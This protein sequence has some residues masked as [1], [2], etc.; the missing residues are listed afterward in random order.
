VW[1]VDPM[2]LSVVLVKFMENALLIVEQ[3]LS[4][5]VPE[6]LTDSESLLCHEEF[7]LTS[8]S[9]R[10]AVEPQGR[11]HGRRGVRSHS[12]AN[13][14][15]IVIGLSI[16]I[17]GGL[18]VCLAGDL[19]RS[20]VDQVGHSYLVLQLRDEL[21]Q[22]KRANHQ[23]HTE[24]VGIKD[25]TGKTVSLNGALSA[26]LDELKHVVEGATGLSVFKDSP[27]AE[28]GVVVAKGD[29]AGHDG[30]EV[31]SLAAILDSPQ[32]RSRGRSNRFRSINRG[33]GGAEVACAR[34]QEGRIVCRSGGTGAKKDVAWRSDSSASF[35]DAVFTVPGDGVALAPMVSGDRAQGDEQRLLARLQHYTDVLRRL[36]LGVPVKGSLTSG[37][38]YRRSPFSHTGSFHQGIDLSVHNGTRVF[39]TGTG[40]VVDV[41]YDGTYGWRIDI[42]HTPEIVTRYAHLSKVSVKRGQRVDRGDLIALSGS[43]GRS[44]GPHLHY[45]VRYKGRARNPAPYLALSRKLPRSLTTLS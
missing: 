39:S 21:D 44:T 15:V 12:I 38:G 27:Q 33:V 3:D 22:L 13:T 31:G 19:M 43:T 20:T 37:F 2:V 24:L 34:D 10:V 14:L 7:V 16:G 45:E 32:L 17:A 40:V 11:P 5:P 35:R 8:D 23:L 9:P 42:A 4:S 18:A 25:Q 41:D 6:R 26:S 1:L 28:R 30:G 29:T 36:P